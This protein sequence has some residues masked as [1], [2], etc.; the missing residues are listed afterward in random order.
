[1]QIVVYELWKLHSLVGFRTCSIA[2][3]NRSKLKSDGELDINVM[4]SSEMV[5]SKA[6]EIEVPK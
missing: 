1:M 2:Y 3:P 5:C 4:A 6:P